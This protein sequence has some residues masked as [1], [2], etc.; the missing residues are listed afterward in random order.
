MRQ[1]ERSD[2]KRRAKCVTSCSNKLAFER[3]ARSERDGM[4][5]KIKAAVF[6]LNRFESGIDLGLVCNVAWNH[7]RI[8]Q[9]IG[10]LF[11]LFLKP[12]TLKRESEFCAMAAAR[13]GARPRDRALV[14]D[15]EDHSDLVFKHIFS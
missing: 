2:L 6:V 9:F 10:E 14:R 11:D 8:G 5:E 13:I 4:H 7:E 15:A 3:F 12:L 1:R